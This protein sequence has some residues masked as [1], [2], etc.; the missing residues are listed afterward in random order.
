[1]DSKDLS[2]SD[3]EEL[4]IEDGTFDDKNL[5]NEPVFTELAEKY[6]QTPAQIILKWHNQMGCIVIPGSR[7]PEHIKEN[8]DIFDFELTPEEMSA[9]AKL[10]KG[11]RYYNGGEA[12]LKQYATW[13]P[14]Y[15]Q[16]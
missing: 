8:V 16:E 7:N 9:I 15:E 13:Q 14:E 5:I 4:G 10:N 3:L 6:H 11:V 1:M 2:E 12:E